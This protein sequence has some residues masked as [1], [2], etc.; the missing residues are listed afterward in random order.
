MKFGIPRG[1]RVYNKDLE[2]FGIVTDI[3]TELMT[4]KTRV[5]VLNDTGDLAAWLAD[6][7]IFID[8]GGVCPACFGSG[9]IMER[10]KDIKPF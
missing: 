1:T 3:L 10:A 2:E 6:D 8:T 9:H 7:E 4:S 5:I